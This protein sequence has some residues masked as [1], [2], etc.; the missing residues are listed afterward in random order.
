MTAE[1]NRGKPEPMSHVELTTE[2]IT[3]ILGALAK[4]QYALARYTEMKG[5]EEP[6]L[7]ELTLLNKIVEKLSQA[8]SSHASLP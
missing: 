2:E 7:R 6:V 4:Q 8:R 5:A 3:Y 1:P